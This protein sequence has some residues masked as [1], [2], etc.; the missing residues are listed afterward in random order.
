MPKTKGR[1]P[2]APVQAA[3][4]I[5]LWGAVLSQ[6]QR[7]ARG[8]FFVAIGKESNLSNADLVR[9]TLRN[10]FEEDRVQ[11]FVTSAIGF[12]V[13]RT[14]RFDEEDFENVDERSGPSP[15]I[16]GPIYPI[17]VIEPLIWLGQQLAGRP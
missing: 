17:N 14:G 9:D 8:E 6:G 4:K 13:D 2:A 7:Q 11:F 12:R 3:G 15:R 16:R 1:P 5:G 10:F